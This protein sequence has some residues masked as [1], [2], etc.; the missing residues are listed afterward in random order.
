MSEYRLNSNITSIASSASIELMEKAKAMRSRGIDIINLSGG[1]P[2]FDTPSI[3]AEAGCR[4]IKAGK[5]HYC[6]GNGLP[7]LRERI[8]QKLNEE[9]G[10]SCSAENILVTPGAKYAV[11]TAVMTLLPPGSEVIIPSPSWLS[12]GPIVSLCGCIPVELK[13]SFEDKY[14]ITVE[15][16]AQSLSRNTRALIINTP[17]N[18]TS[19]IL[20]A[21][22]SEAIAS[23][24]LAHNLYIIADEIYEKIVYD[25]HRHI[26]LGARGDIA[27]NV[28]TVNGL[29]KSAAMTGWR[30]GYMCAPKEVINAASIFY[31]HTMTC[32]SE[33]A[34]EAAT[35]ALDCSED[36]ERMRAAYERRKNILT[37]GLRDVPG[38]SFIEPE[39]TFYLWLRVTGRQGDPSEMLL[40]KANIVA[41]PGSHYCTGANDCVRFCFAEK[42][43]IIQ[44]AAINIRRALS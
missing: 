34:Q 24:V 41:V 42:D 39:G 2:D 11:Y 21:E 20:S 29:S 18:P 37:E 35:V 27:G 40:K 5:T 8:A 22:E 43:E 16:L 10:I 23:F 1:E 19:R 33:F 13:L 38:L 31:Q 36:I 3:V 12:Y 28:I 26:S 44:R 6:T 30:V 7:A 14:T 17:N 9:N 32:I 15:K 4:A 25:G